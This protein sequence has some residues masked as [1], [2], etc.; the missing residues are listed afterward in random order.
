MQTHSNY[1]FTRTSVAEITFSEIAAQWIDIKRQE[2]KGI[3]LARYIFLLQKHI[4]P[5]YGSMPIASIDQTT[6]NQFVHY[7]QT[8][9]CPTSSLSD[10]YVSS[11]LVV[12]RAI[13]QFATEQG[14]TLSF[15]VANRFG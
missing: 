11:M 1:Q 3:S 5:H 15:F 13:L 2:V 6:L 10:G 12:I 4:L 8:Q 7:K 14:H 9:E